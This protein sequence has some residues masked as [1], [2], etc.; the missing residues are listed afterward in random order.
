MYIDNAPLLSKSYSTDK[1]MRI[2]KCVQGFEKHLE[3]DL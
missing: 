1:S 2:V 3:I